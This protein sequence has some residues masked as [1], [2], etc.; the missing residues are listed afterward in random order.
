MLIQGTSYTT[1]IK[2][3]QPYDGGRCYLDTAELT[4]DNGIA[5]LASFDTLM[6]EGSLKHRFK[7]NMPNVAFPYTKNLSVKATA[8]NKNNTVSTNVVVLGKRPRNVNFAST[9]PALPLM[10]LRDPPGDGSNAT[11]EKGREICNGWSIGTSAEMKASTGLELDLGTETVVSAGIGAEVET[12]TELKNS[13]DMK[14]SI[15]TKGNFNKSAEVCLTATET[16][17]TSGDGVLQGEDA[18]VFVGGTF[19]LLFGLTDKLLFDTLNCEYVLDK[20]LVVFP[21]RFASTFLYSGY[22]IKKVVIPNLESIGDMASARQWRAI[23]KRNEDLKK[24][25][26]FQRNIT[27]D[28]GVTYE[29]STAIQNTN[30]TKYG[31]GID[32]SA[33]INAKLGFAFNG[34]GSA[35]TLGMEITMGVNT[36]FTKKETNTQTVK[37]NLAD[38]DLKDAFTVDVLED[39]VYGTPVFKTISGNSSCPYEPNTVPRDGLT[40][41]VDRTIATN[42]LA[43]EP[44]VFKFNL[45]NVSQTDEPRAYTLALYNG[46]NTNAAR[47]KVQG[48]DKSSGNFLISAGQSQEVIVTVERGPTAYAYENLSIYAISD[49][50]GARYDALGFGDWPPPP[51]FK[52]ILLDVY[53]LEPCSPIDIGFPLQNWVMTPSSGDTMFITLNK[54]NRSDTDLELIRVQYRRKQGDGAWINIVEVPKAELDNDVFKIVQWITTGLKDGE[55]EL[56]AVTQCTGG[57]NAGISTVISGRFEREAPEILG[58]PEPADGVLSIGDE[59]SITFT[60]PIKCD[61]LIQADFFNNNNIGLYNTQTGKLVDAVITCNR[62]KIVVVPNVPNRF[63]ENTVLRVQ[64][65]NIK[66]LVGNNFLE[67]KWEFFVDRNPVRWVEDQIAVVKQEEEIVTVTRKLENI[68]GQALVYDL[69]GAPNWVKVFPMGGTLA[70]GASQNVVFTFDNATALGSYTDTIYADG[71]LGAEPI[72]L[73]LRVACPSPSWAL[74]RAGYSF[75]MNMTL[76]LN[77]EGTVSGD[78]MDIVAAFVGRELRGLG[79]VQY[80]PELKKHLVFLTVYSNQAVG[81]TVT[82]QVWDASA[83]KLYGSTIETFAFQADGL[84]GSPL[85]PQV[86]RTNNLLLAKVPLN[87]GWNWISYNVGLMDPAINKGLASLSSPQGGL[88]KGQTSFSSYSNTLQTW[89]GNLKNLSHLTMYQ[90]KSSSV[91]SL[92]LLGM[93]VDPS[94]PIPVV[95]GWNW[96]GFLPQRGMRV[97]EAL[98]SLTPLNGDLVKGQFTFAQYVAGLGWIGN[99]SYMSSPHG[100]LLKLSNA[101]TLVYPSTIPGN[102][103]QE[104]GVEKGKFPN[105]G[106]D[107]LPYSYWKVKPE[108]YEQSM[109][110]IAVVERPGEGNILGAGDEIGAFFREEVRGS[111]Q[112]LYIEAL[113]A[114]LVFLTVYANREGEPIRFRY[115][116][117]SEGRVIELNETAVFRSNSLEGLAE[118]PL[119]LTPASPTGINGLEGLEGDLEVYPNPTG[120]VAFL[121]FELS[122]RQAL[123]LVV[124][125]AL[126]R[127][128]WRTDYEG[129]AG[130]NVVEWRPE[131]DL[132]SGWYFAT[133]RGKKG[134]KTAKV[135]LIR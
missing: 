48:E 110:I 27:F 126:G 45:G 70:P 84:V 88:I 8:N 114:Y 75:S 24:A 116:D 22:Q 51:F 15:T 77:I 1:E 59:I 105:A 11:I 21:D 2:V 113:D 76:E 74:N 124:T 96:V 117:A 122:E 17:S 98:G 82:F 56:R 132:P 41:T 63:I 53:F 127:E 111:S 40:L 78:G 16:I 60:E 134:V 18:D 10:I 73:D 32:V 85:V 89:A 43:N 44:A 67:K 62:D 128:V 36:E 55:Y 91:D 106:A 104:G 29:N 130:R 38:D 81:E 93:P 30:E 131:V 64:V 95:S 3:Y 28:A 68:G 54:Y 57:Q 118:K 109:N 26:V 20:D 121:Q 49:C 23:L 71:P 4:I 5:D 69:Q 42:V 34:T 129:L 12:K 66:D 52:E 39:R 61:A 120:E 31:F 101:G 108:S 58:V 83:C 25:A 115:Y 19:N 92:L 112:V 6:T 125:D 97:W 90:Y 47:V 119:V 37:F 135:E 79:K 33:E 35:F 86:L 14:M 72:Y 100:Y 7:A 65:N 107:A 50:E 123:T 9:S 133:L 94:T 46:S 87:P 103:A 99:L 80:S 102:N 13:L